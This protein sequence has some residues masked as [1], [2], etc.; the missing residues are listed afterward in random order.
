[1][2]QKV[3]KHLKFEKKWAV[4]TPI[5]AIDF[6]AAQLPDFSKSQLK[7]VMNIGGVWLIRK[8]K[9]IIMRKAQKP[10]E[11]GDQVALYYDEK[12]LF[13]KP[14]TPICLVHEHHYSVW[15]K[16]ANMV[17]QGSVY[18]D[19]LSL[20][21]IVEQML[22]RSCFLVHRLD[23]EVHGLVIM[24]HTVQAAA[25]FSAY[26]RDNRIQKR[27][28]AFVL[29]QLHAMDIDT[30]IDGKTALTRCQP[31]SYD[32]KTNQT[33]VNISIETGRKHQIRV[34]LAD[35]GYPIMGDP[36]YGKGNKNQ[37]G[38]QLK[39]TELSFFDPWK[40]QRCQFVCP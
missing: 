2:D 32:E 13:E 28:Q 7:K 39:A 35:V 38:L 4:V 11:V 8:G 26:F 27:Y 20:F 29:G 22:N 6:I 31:L 40:K 3:E 23:R 37:E 9:T 14:L 21:R 5:S 16:P 18:S 17:S 25:E 24:A 33:L 36:L 1:V 34:H 10:L 19:H 30:P 12:L 15:I